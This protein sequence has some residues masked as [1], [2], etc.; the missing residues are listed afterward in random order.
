MQQQSL[1]VSSNFAVCLG[2]VL[3]RQDP[4]FV[5]PLS[6]MGADLSPAEVKRIY[7]K[8]SKIIPERNDWLRSALAEA[9]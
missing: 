9:I 8:I 5:A 3:S 7:N 2:S 4:S 6:Q 1:S